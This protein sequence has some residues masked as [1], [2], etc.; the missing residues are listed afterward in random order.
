MKKKTEEMF[1]RNALEWAKA[2]GGRQEFR[3]K[4]NLIKL[5]AP[6]WVDPNEER[7]EEL[8]K[9]RMKERNRG[10][11]EKSVKRRR[12]NGKQPPKHDAGSN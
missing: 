11:H 8:L 5:P 12:L 7:L 6:Y 10:D 9:E 3:L 4:Y 2:P 1:A